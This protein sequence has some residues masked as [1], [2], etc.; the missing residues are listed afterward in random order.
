[1]IV[2]HNSNGMGAAHKNTQGP[3]T[4]KVGDGRSQYFLK[5]NHTT[6]AYKCS[7]HEKMMPQTLSSE[8]G[9]KLQFVA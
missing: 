3:S 5:S 9:N 8:M 1:M 7:Q 2:T 4:T 6:L